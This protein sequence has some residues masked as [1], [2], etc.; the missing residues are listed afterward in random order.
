MLFVKGSKIS[1]PTGSAPAVTTNMLPEAH[2][3]FIDLSKFSWF[4]GLQTCGARTIPSFPEQNSGTSAVASS[5]V[6][7]RAGFMFMA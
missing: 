6:A 1:M 3:S 4:P 2:F 7:M 5:S